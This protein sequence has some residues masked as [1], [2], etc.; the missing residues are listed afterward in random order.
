MSGALFMILIEK[1]AYSAMVEVL[2]LP[3][4]QWK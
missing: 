1:D 3:Q 2:T 4:F